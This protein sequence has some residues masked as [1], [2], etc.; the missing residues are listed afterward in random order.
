MEAALQLLEVV[1]SL[2]CYTGLL[3]GALWLLKEVTMGMYLG[4]QRLDGRLVVV[5]G[6]NCGIGLEVRELL[7]YTCTRLRKFWS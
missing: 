6:A 2:A 3:M 1:S 7:Y 5:T 4:R